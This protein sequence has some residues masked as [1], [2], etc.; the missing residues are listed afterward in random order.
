MPGGNITTIRQDMLNN[1]ILCDHDSISRPFFVK[2]CE[3]CES[4]VSERGFTLHNIPL[5]PEY[6]W[7]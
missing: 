5:S 4:E 1:S 2:L 6:T 7:E 3:P